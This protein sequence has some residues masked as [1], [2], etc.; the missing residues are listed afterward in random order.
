M[1]RAKDCALIYLH[2]CFSIGSRTDCY[3][4]QAQ[5]ERDAPEDSS[6]VQSTETEMDEKI[7]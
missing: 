2:K 3:A 1:H 5:I 4:T 6:V 7:L